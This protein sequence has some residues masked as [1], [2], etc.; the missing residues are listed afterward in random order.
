MVYFYVD[1]AQLG[2]CRSNFTQRL[3]NR[4][5]IGECQLWEA[6]TAQ[7]T[8]VQERVERYREIDGKFIL[9]SVQVEK[10]EFL[11]F[12]PSSSPGQCYFQFEALEW[13]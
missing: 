8:K 5:S 3:R 2:I 10:F 6:D 7:H 1:V 13:F 4:I 12:S 11:K 9:V